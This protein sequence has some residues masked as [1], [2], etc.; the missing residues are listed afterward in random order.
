[1]VGIELPVWPLLLKQVPYSHLVLSENNTCKRFALFQDFLDA[2]CTKRIISCSYTFR[3]IL[4]ELLLEMAMEQT[5]NEARVGIERGAL[6]F[7]A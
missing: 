6:P 3:R 2:A 4:L 1:M 5:G 7:Q